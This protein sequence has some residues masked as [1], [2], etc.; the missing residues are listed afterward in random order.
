MFT[1]HVQSAIGGGRPLGHDLTRVSEGIKASLR[2]FSSSV[3]RSEEGKGND[4]GK[5]FYLSSGHL[6]LLFS[7]QYDQ[8]A[9]NLEL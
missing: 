9:T 3:R 7:I 4:N 5:F 6:K 2:A 1:R 8:E